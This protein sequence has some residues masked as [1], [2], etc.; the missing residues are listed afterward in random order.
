MLK[1]IDVFIWACVLALLVTLISLIANGDEPE[2]LSA[3]SVDETTTYIR[4]M[5]PVSRLAE[6]NQIERYVSWWLQNYP[7]R[8]AVALTYIDPILYWSAFYGLDPLLVSII[9]SLES[10]WVYKSVGGRKEYG[11][12]QVHPSNSRDLDT[13]TPIGQIQ[14]GTRQLRRCYTKCGPRTLKALNCYGTKGGKCRP[15]LS[16]AKRRVRIYRRMQEMFDGT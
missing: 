10:S 3:T 5:P 4:P 6:A 15:I 11:L 8:R 14:A 16:F 13:S 7:R 12:M 2:A 1:F 9:I